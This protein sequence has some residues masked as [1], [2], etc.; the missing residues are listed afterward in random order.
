MKAYGKM[1][2]EKFPGA[3]LLNYSLQSINVK[4]NINFKKWNK[5]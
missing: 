5:M 3:T 4:I 2:M 1:L